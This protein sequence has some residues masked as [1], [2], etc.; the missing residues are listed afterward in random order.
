[1]FLASKKV[2]AG[3][4]WPR[5]WENVVI[6]R[7][8]LVLKPEIWQLCTRFGLEKSTIGTGFEVIVCKLAE[9]MHQVQDRK[10]GDF[11]YCARFGTKY[12]KLHIIFSR[13]NRSF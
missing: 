3:G 4:F 12:G 6:S 10:N 5:F 7:I 9:I 1:M 11:A 8:N 13:R 2:C